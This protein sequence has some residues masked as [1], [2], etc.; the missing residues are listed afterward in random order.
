MRETFSIDG[1]HVKLHGIFDIKSLAFTLD[2]KRVL[3]FIE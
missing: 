1:A 2:T 3:V